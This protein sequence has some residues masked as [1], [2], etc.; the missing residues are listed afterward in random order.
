MIIKDIVTRITGIPSCIEIPLEL[1]I[2]IV[3]YGAL[4]ILYWSD[5]VTDMIEPKKKEEE[6]K[7]Q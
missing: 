4:Q 2:I 6:K 1:G 7:E 3:A 5:V